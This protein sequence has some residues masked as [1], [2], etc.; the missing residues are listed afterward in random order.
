MAASL[1]HKRPARRSV[2]LHGFDYAQTGRYF[3]TICAFEKLCLFGRIENEMFVPSPLGSIARRCWLA[4]PSHF[5]HVLTDAFV[6]M[7]NHMHG[8]LLI[9]GGHGNAVPLQGLQREAF[10]APVSGS[11]PTIVRSFKAAATR[12]A[13]VYVKQP[14]L[15]LW[16]RGYFERVLR[17]DKE[18]SYA[19]R[20]VLENPQRW[21]LDQLHR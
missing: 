19:A 2:R 8:I 20:Y 3:I 13:R 5:S 15:K 12:D 1:E 16:Q 6:I 11:I 21:H 17:N 7:P 4:I 9:T 18:F 10:Q 14:D